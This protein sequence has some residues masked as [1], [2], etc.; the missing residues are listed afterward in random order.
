VFVFEAFA[1]APDETLKGFGSLIVQEVL[2]AFLELIKVFD[3]KNV[4]GL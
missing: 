2:L 3:R 1:P 4:S